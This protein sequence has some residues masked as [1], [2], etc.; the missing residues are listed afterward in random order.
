[1]WD[2]I[3]ANSI[4]LEISG[5]A[6]LSASCGAEGLE[7]VQSEEPDIVVLDLMMD[8]CEKFFKG[9]LA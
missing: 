6:V 7:K 1:M 8:E 2:F 9:A 3:K 5:F 4:I